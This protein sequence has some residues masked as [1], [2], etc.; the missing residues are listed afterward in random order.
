MITISERWVDTKDNATGNQSRKQPSQS[1]SCLQ[2]QFYQKN[3]YEETNIEM[4]RTV[5][6]VDSW[7]PMSALKTSVND[8]INFGILLV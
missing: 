8:G 4:E 1:H 7:E 2:K 3:Y 6:T 5:Q